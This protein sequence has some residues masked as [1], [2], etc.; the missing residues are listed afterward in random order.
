MYVCM[1]KGTL[2]N[3]SGT[4]VGVVVRNDADSVVLWY[5][6]TVRSSEEEIGRLSTSV[7][8]VMKSNGTRESSNSW[9]LA[10]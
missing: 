5:G 6:G 10:G 1:V 9:L 4:S 7:R 8:L 3:S 2:E